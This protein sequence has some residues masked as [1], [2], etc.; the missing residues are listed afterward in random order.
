MEASPH[1]TLPHLL[2]SG[3]GKQEEDGI[4]ALTLPPQEVLS[5][6][7]GWRET[8]LRLL[9]NRSFAAVFVFQDPMVYVVLIMDQAGL[10][11]KRV[12]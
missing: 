11:L 5:M 10:Q 2:G 6:F 1:T 8:L 12:N 9:K 7:K 4:S 3:Q